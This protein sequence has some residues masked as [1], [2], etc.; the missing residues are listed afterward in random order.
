MPVLTTTCC[1]LGFGGY[2]IRAGFTQS[3]GAVQLQR[4]AEE[5]WQYLLRYEKMLLYILPA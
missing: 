3:G 4:K 5:G 2:K 1:S